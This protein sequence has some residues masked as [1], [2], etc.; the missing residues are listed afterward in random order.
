MANKPNPTSRRPKG[1][2][3]AAAN[4]LRPCFRASV[5]ASGEL[6]VLIYDEIGEYFDWDTW[7]MA[8]ITSKSV[9]QTLDDAGTFSRIKLRINS[10][11]GDAFEGVAIGNVLKAAGK[12]IDVYIDGLAASA[13]SLVAM[14]GDRIVMASNAM[15]MVHQAWSICV[16][17]SD[18][19]RKMADTL[20]AID[21]GSV[22]QTYVDKTGRPMEEI[23]ALMKEETWLSA[24]DCVEKGF[25]TEIAGESN[26]PALAMAKNFR[27]IAK[28]KR[29]PES[30]RN[31]GAPPRVANDDMDDECKCLCANCLDGDCAHCTDTTCQDPNCIDC[32]NQDDAEAKAQVQTDIDLCEVTAAAN[33]AKASLLAA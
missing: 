27:A 2:H 14:C 18:D 20:D 23:M 13:A 33:R 1:R 9:R 6:E 19:M 8:G 25:A 21:Q 24:R 28:M 32:P 10:P 5:Q 22:A 3:P 31:A 17:N 12:P 26:E 11:G 30:L 15:Q 4:R 16:G 29:V 7:E